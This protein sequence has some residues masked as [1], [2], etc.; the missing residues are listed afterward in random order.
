[1]IDHKIIIAEL[2]KRQDLEAQYHTA[3]VLYG[4]IDG[5][6]RYNSTFKYLLH[7]LQICDLYSM[8]KRHID[9][10]KEID[11]HSAHWTSKPNKAQEAFVAVCKLQESFNGYAKKDGLTTNL[12]LAL[13]AHC[14]KIFSNNSKKISFEQN[15]EKIQSQKNKYQNVT[16]KALQQVIALVNSYCNPLLKIS[17]IHALFLLYRPLPKNNAVIAKLI[18]SWYIQPELGLSQNFAFLSS[19]FNNYREL[20]LEAISKLKSTG[21][22]SEWIN[23]YGNALLESGH[24]ILTT[25][26]DFKKL[27]KV[28]R[29]KVKESVNGSKST[30]KVHEV[31]LDFPVASSKHITQVANRTPATVNSSL[32]VLVDLGILKEKTRY[33]RNRVFSYTEYIELLD[34]FC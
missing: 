22:W 24:K 6:I 7:N 27:R 19:Y 10:L 28:N 32:Q 17:I 9:T 11:L 34:I 14:D 8:V 18:T 20:G 21:D 33:K 12:L 15:I 16:L 13:D 2:K 29:K 23:F 31:L 3:L 1:M 26:D 30:L 4:R 5:A 25:I